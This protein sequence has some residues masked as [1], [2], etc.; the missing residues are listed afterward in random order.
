MRT[1]H[2]RYGIAASA[3]LSPTSLAATGAEEH[4]VPTQRL[5]D[6]ESLRSLERAMEEF[7]V[8][9]VSP[10]PTETSWNFTSM[11][12]D[13]ARTQ[14][15]STQD[16]DLE[17]NHELA[18]RLARTLTHRPLMSRLARIEAAYAELPATLEPPIVASVPPPLP[19]AAEPPA[20]VEPLKHLE[21]A[22]P[23]GATRSIDE[24][25]EEFSDTVT[26]LPESSTAW[27]GNARRARNRSFLHNVAG[28]FA[29]IAIGA[30]VIAGA[31]FMLRA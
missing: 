7:D 10:P 17:H 18:A 14:D 30:T 31:I 4:D 27:L 26:P 3:A 5:R 22:Q 24:L 9:G 16:D 8:S 12:A 28:W 11:P 20:A 29:T 15:D 21:P 13:A 23:N 1:P 25:M 19:P 2:G 6:E